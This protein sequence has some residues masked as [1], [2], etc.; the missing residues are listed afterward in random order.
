MERWIEKAAAAVLTVVFL[1]LVRPTQLPAL[2][3]T[4]ALGIA[5]YEIALGAVEAFIEVLHEEDF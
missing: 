1:A 3:I 5:F 2:W 4:G